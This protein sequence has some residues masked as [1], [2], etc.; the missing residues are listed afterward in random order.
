[1]VVMEE[2]IEAFDAALEINVY[3]EGVKTVYLPDGPLFESLMTKWRNTVD[4]ARQMPAYGV[5][6]HNLTVAALQEGVWVEFGFGG[7]CSCNGMPFERLLVEVKESFTGFNVIRYTA[8]RGYDGRCFYLS[9]R[10]DMAAFA[11]FLEHL[12]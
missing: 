2:I 12:G 3:R 7:V 6:L 11:L 9:L 4:G 8:E 5:S 1:M 10:G